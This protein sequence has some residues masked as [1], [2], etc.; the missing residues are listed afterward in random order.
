MLPDASEQKLRRSPPAPKLA[1]VSSGPDERPSHKKSR[2][3]SPRHGLTRLKAAV[4]E[5]GGRIIDG[6]TTLG[7]TLVEWRLELIEDLGG[8]DAVSTQEKAVIELAVKTKL[9]LVLS[10]AVS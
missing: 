7:K 2:Q 5:L 1:N 10:P 4:R 8:S 3:S 6:R 9:L